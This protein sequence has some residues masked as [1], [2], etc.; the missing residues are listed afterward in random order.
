MSKY[1]YYVIREQLSIVVCL[2]QIA[3]K[4]GW[5]FT[6]IQEDKKTFNI[7]SLEDERDLKLLGP[8]GLH[9]QAIYEGD[10]PEGLQGHVQTVIR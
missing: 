10:I 5:F 1:N 9:L 3:A 6:T 2:L 8:V 7:V 4:G